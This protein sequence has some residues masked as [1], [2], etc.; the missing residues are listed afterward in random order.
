MPA[1]TIR[2][3]DSS[4]HPDYIGTAIKYAHTRDEA[5]QCLAGKQGKWDKKLNIVID[6][7]GSRLDILPE[8]TQT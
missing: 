2:F 3:K 6:K 7:Y 5:I 4:M 1:H 8:D